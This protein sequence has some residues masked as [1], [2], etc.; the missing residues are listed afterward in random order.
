MGVSWGRGVGQ[1]NRNVGV[2][3]GLVGLGGG[4][5]L[6]VVGPYVSRGRAPELVAT[7][8]SK[9]TIVFCA[10]PSSREC[11]KRSEA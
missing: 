5:T 11:F 8:T 4:M 10:V 2:G 7:T 9:R 1:C 3:H 6:A